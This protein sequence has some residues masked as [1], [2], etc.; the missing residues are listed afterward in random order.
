MAIPTQDRAL[1]GTPSAA[2]RAEPT[3][4]SSPSPFLG[5][6][7]PAVQSESSGDAFVLTALS[8]PHESVEPSRQRE[9]QRRATAEQ[10]PSPWLSLGLG[11]TRLQAETQHS[12]L[13][14]RQKPL[15]RA[16][17]FCQDSY[18]SSPN[19]PHLHICHQQRP[20][21]TKA[22]IPRIRGP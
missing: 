6:G 15:E 2:C 19:C 1:S 16:A 21:G 3:Q 9:G 11:H 17:E 8:H 18:S 5:T 13:T 4:G 22:S 20:R 7:C 14:A 12:A 10:Y